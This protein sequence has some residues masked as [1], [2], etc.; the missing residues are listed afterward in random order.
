[1]IEKM[2]GFHFVSLIV[3]YV[4]VHG[5]RHSSRVGEPK[6]NDEAQAMR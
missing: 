5:L 6:F 1:M 2:A 4:N 3:V